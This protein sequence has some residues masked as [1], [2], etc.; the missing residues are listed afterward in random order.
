ML[1]DSSL[2]DSVPELIYVTSQSA[3]ARRIQRPLHQHN[4]LAELFFLYQGHG[5]YV[6]DGY[7]YQIH[8]GDILLTN[9]GSMHEVMPDSEREMG[10]VCFGVADLKLAGKE[11][12]FLTTFQDG[13]VR[14]TEDYFPTMKSIGLTIYHLMES[15]DATE[16]GAA[17]HLFLGFLLLA[18]CCHADERSKAPDKN[19]VL[20]TR[21]HQYITLHYTE[22]LTLQSIAETLHI[23]P[24]YASHI[25]KEQFGMSPIQF[26]INCRIGE[27]QNLLIANDYSAAQIAAMVGY[28]SINHFNSI[29]KE[30]V[31]M[32]PI[33]YRKYYLEQMRGKRVQ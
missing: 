15:N 9:R 2:F 11:K 16:R 30:K 6:C 14:P 7:S 19:I 28:D 33:Q 8:P 5:M 12:G 23:S 29:F 22:A 1:N 3:Y 18:L 21:L 26:M 25:F 4:D 32:P 27:A 10:A 20:A 13:F 17:Q 31:G 24:Y